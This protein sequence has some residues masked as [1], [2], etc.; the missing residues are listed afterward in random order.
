MKKFTLLFI[1][2]VAVLSLFSQPVLT[3]SINL[4]IGD[5][6]RYDGYSEVTNIEPGPGGAKFFP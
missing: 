2:I 4:N 6:Y 3:N 5:T 1:S